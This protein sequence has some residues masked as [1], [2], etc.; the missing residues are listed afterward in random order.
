MLMRDSDLRQRVT[1]A[2]FILQWCSPRHF[3]VSKSDSLPRRHARNPR[4]SLVDVRDGV[5][6]LPM[7]I[8][9]ALNTL[10]EIG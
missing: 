8:K 5:F 4:Q 3:R 6:M 7:L 10:G 1:A 2:P 9:R